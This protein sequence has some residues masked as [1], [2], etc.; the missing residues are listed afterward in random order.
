MRVESRPKGCF[1]VSRAGETQPPAGTDGGPP[2]SKTVFL[3]LDPLIADLE[4]KHGG[5]VT[6]I[7]LE[8]RPWGAHYEVELVDG[9][10]VEWDI[11]VDVRSHEILRERREFDF[12]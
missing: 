2:G 11:V 3:S 8:R 1:A 4:K 7:D 10:F 12:D 6:E 9:T 5:R